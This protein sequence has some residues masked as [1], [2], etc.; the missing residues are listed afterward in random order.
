MA[1]KIMSG[2]SVASNSG[3]N[4][5]KRKR[6]ASV[7]VCWQHLGGEENIG[8]AETTSAMPCVKK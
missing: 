6:A 8:V 7:T 2:I 1:K 3:V 4:Q 5:R